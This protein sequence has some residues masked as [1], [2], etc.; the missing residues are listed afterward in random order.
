MP[1]GVGAFSARDINL[2]L[3]DHG[4]RDRGAE[5]IVTLVHGV[6]A[7]QRKNEIARELLAQIDQMKFARAG[8]ERLFFEAD[9]FFG[10]PDFGAKRDDLAS[11]LVLDPA[12]D[13]RG[14]EPAGIG[15]HH[16]FDRL[17]CHFSFPRAERR[18]A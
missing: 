4:A 2:L 14:I 11:E 12:Q 13:H 1:D 18:A 10:L 5:E 17:S 3:R 8:L 6:G 7:N 9:G 15:E 16:F